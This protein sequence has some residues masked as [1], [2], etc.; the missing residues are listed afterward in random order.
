MANWLRRVPAYP[1]GPTLFSQ[2]LAAIQVAIDA[3]AQ[4]QSAA[5]DLLKS[6]FGLELQNIL[7]GLQLALA[8]LSGALPGV[9]GDAAM[10]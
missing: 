2:A 1:S 6:S 3:I 7:A 5:S 4:I 10:R 9:T 8:E